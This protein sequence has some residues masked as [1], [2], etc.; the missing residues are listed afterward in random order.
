[1][2]MRVQRSTDLWSS[3]MEDTNTKLKVVQDSSVQQFGAERQEP[4]QERLSL[5]EFESVVEGISSAL[6]IT[7]RGL[8]FTIHKETERVMV[9]VIDRDTQEVIKEI[10]PE[11]V[12]DMV[13][14]IHEMIGLMIDERA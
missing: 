6:E 2:S 7:N 11:N 5:E 1:M 10:P 13:A 9:K 8:E 12:L 14:R 4:H 3:S